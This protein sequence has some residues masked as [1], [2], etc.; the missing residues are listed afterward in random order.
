M[1]SLLQ[2]MKV[3]MQKQFLEYNTNL[4][5]VAPRIQ[6]TEYA[7]RLELGSDNLGLVKRN[8]S[9]TVILHTMCYE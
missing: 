4:G 1:E 6:H 3:K 8:T 5:L 2:A 9:C 7:I